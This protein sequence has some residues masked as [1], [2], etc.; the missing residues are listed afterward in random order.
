MQTCPHCNI[1]ICIRKLRHQGLF[2]NYRVCQ[3]CENRFTVDTNTKYLQAVCIFVAIISLVI[4]I[5]MYFQG[6]TWIIPAIISYFVLVLIIFW[7]NK[8][9][10]LVPYAKDEN[11]TNDS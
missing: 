9:V 2:E 4:T 1:E 8:R 11:K 7:G 6:T 5:L 10:F 3:K